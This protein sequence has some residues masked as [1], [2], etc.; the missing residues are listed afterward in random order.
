[1]DRLLRQLLGLQPAA[2][3]TLESWWSATRDTRETESLP[4][5]HALIGGV[6]AD[7]LGF[8][9]AAGY[10]AALQV[11]VGASDGMTSLCVTEA[12]GNRPKD[13][14]TTLTESA[15]GAFELSGA[16]KW[17]TGGPL[18][19]QLIVI[20]KTGIDAEGRNMLRAVRVP[21]GA[22]GVRIVASSA[23]F[24]P[25][26]PHAEVTL[27]RVAVTAADL[28][29]GDGYDDYVKPFRTIEDAHVHAAVLGYLLGVAR[30]IAAPK[31][32]VESLLATALAMRAITL[33]DPKS[34]ATHVAL[35][36]AM[37]RAGHLV[38]EVQSR[39]EDADTSPERDRWQRDR[40]L[41][42]VAGAAR[43][44]RREKAWELLASGLVSS[45]PPPHP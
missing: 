40:A 32:L 29:P 1:M 19:S 5:D 12:T 27:D 2:L 44:A 11:L 43:V 8:A 24:V 45:A 37:A 41:L 38:G 13:I 22:P 14:A 26:I 3:D 18:A 17:A 39:W 28:L 31:E 9:F 21:A 34:P 23:P 4:A 10:Q 36:G 25:E 33:C 42:R 35:A 30:R 20:A 15:P 16:K 6:L 7:R